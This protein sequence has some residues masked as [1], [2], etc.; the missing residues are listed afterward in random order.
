MTRSQKDALVSPPRLTDS[1]PEDPRDLI[2]AGGPAKS[3]LQSYFPQ[4]SRDRESD[5]EIQHLSAESRHMG[6][7][8]KLYFLAVGAALCAALAL[9]SA[10]TAATSPRAP[11]PAVASQEG[12]LAGTGC[13]SLKKKAQR[14]KRGSA[15]RRRYV[16]RYRSCLA[17]R[18][19]QTPPPPAQAPSTPAPPAVTQ[20]AGPIYLPS[21]LPNPNGYRSGGGCQPGYEQT[22]RAAGFSCQYAGYNRYLFSPTGPI[23][24]PVYLLF[25]IWYCADGQF[26]FRC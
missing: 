10:S 18:R 8:A 5:A 11:A 16:R 4:G 13:A 17:R 25:G 15:K 9:A 24:T 23:W 26:R 22:Y 21:I 2:F 14:S 20:P 1:P 3:D 6:R 7:L 19:V 12:H